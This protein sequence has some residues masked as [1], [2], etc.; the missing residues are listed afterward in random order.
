[1][2]AAS[3]RI[4]SARPTSSRSAPRKGY[5][6][7]RMALRGALTSTWTRWP[8]GFSSTW[9][10]TSFGM[11]WARTGRGRPQGAGRDGHDQIRSSHARYC[12][13]RPGGTEWMHRRTPPAKAGRLIAHAERSHRHGLSRRHRGARHRSG[14]ARTARGRPGESQRIG[15]AVRGGP[16]L[17]QTAAQSLDSRLDH[18]RQRGLPG[19]RLDHPPR[20]GHA[21]SKELWGTGDPPASDCCAAAPPVLE[22]DQAGNLLNH[23]GGAGQGFE[24]PESNHGITVDSKGIVW[25]GGNGAS[26]GHILKFTRDGKFVKQ[27]GFQ[28]SERRQ[29][30]HV[31][32][33][34]RREGLPRREKRRYVADG[35]GNKRVAVIDMDSGKIKRYWVVRQQA[36]RCQPRPVP[37]LPPAGA[38]V[39]RSSALRR[40]LERRV[41]LRVRSRERSRAGV[42]QRRDVRKRGVRPEEHRGDGSASD[43]AF[44]KDAQQKSFF[45]ADGAN[46]EIHV[47]DRESLAELRGIRRRRTPA[48]PFYAVHGVAADS[49]A[50]STRRRP[51]RASACS[52]S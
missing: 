40:V 27:F 23:W 43:L 29:Q 49:K 39:P 18:R 16:V 21:R 25:I 9:T 50:T 51:T 44:S 3:C 5:S 12:I 17:A 35:Y 47:F 2:V 41:R 7:S 36:E 8:S 1:M 10:V 34:P 15:S 37:I 33:R 11:S 28:Y 52:D 48:R 31:G 42:P 13:L 6:T 22:F 20:R 24:W 32:V 14:P 46:D 4:A 30:R 26:D 45:L 38:A 19:S